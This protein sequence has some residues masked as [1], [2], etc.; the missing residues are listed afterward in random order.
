MITTITVVFG[1]AVSV[2]GYFVYYKYRFFQQ[3]LIF[4][5]RNAL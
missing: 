5:E 2:R 1:D 3:R 4:F